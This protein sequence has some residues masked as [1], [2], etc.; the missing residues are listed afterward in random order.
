[1]AGSDTARREVRIL[2]Q[3]DSSVYLAAAGKHNAMPM[4]YLELVSGFHKG[5]WRPSAGMTWT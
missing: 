2:K 3:E 5:N 4:F 1:M